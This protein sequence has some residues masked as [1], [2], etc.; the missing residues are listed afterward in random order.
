VQLLELC[1]RRLAQVIDLA[2][3]GRN[4]RMQSI[5]FLGTPQL[6]SEHDLAD[7]FFNRHGSA[8]LL[9]KGK[10]KPRCA[11]I[12]KVFHVFSSRAYAGG[13]RVPGS[14]F[15]AVAIG[16]DAGDQLAAIQE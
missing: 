8:R 9:F 10:A 2:R 14:D 6:F 5:E 7:L 12:A 4:E 13:K 11:I 16:R 15:E 1:R 3:I